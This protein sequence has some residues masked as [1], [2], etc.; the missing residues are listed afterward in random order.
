METEDSHREAITCGSNGSGVKVY[1][2]DADD[3]EYTSTDIIEHIDSITCV[4]ASVSVCAN[5]NKNPSELIVIHIGR[6]FF[7]NGRCRWYCR[8]IQI[9][10]H[11]Q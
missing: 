9:K 1:D 11:L 2:T 10:Q 8:F 3:E 5:K 4:S 7:C 6:R